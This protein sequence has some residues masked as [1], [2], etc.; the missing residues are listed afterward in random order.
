MAYSVVTGTTR[1]RACSSGGCNADE[2][3]TDKNEIGGY[4]KCTCQP[5]SEDP[6]EPEEP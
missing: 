6:E 2:E 1:K 3:C 5:T 4:K